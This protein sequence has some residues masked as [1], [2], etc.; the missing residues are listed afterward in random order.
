METDLDILK[1][2]MEKEHLSQ[3][4]L[5]DMLGIQRQYVNALLKGARSIGAKTKGKLQELFPAYFPDTNK[6]VAYQQPRL[7]KLKY[8][9]DLSIPYNLNCK[10]NHFEVIYIDE[11]VL[12]NQFRVNPS[13]CKLIRVLGD[14]MHPYFND[15]DRVVLDTSVH[16]FI[17]GHI[18]AFSY[19]KQNYV[20]RI[21]V[22]PDNIKC[23]PLNEKYDTFYINPGSNYDIHGLIVPRIRL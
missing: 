21:N 9:L 1:T 3:S 23:I 18:F 16:N 14:A 5:A 13:Y 20:S 10:S 12:Y 19:N 7:I 11:S 4:A 17:D 15:G 6:A 2:I 8:Y 22:L